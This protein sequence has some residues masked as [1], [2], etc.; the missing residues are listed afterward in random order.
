[1]NWDLAIGVMLLGLSGL[2]FITA[3]RWHIAYEGA[4]PFALA[5]VGIASFGFGI[6]VLA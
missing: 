6:G 1:M 3:V 4:A 2:T 5:L